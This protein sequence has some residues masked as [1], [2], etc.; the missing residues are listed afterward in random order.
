M[1]VSNFRKKRAQRSRHQRGQAVT[2]Y[3]LLLCVIVSAFLAVFKSSLSPALAKLSGGISQNI[4]NQFLSTDLHYFP[5][6]H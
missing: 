4:Q 2:E 5:V 3:I 1:D 6:G